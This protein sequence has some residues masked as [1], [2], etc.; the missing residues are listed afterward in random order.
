MFRSAV[1]INFNRTLTPVRHQ[2]RRTLI[3]VS[4]NTQCSTANVRSDHNLVG[5][6]CDAHWTYL[7][8]GHWTCLRNGHWTCHQ[9]NTYRVALAAYLMQTNKS[10]PVS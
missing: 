5:A 1:Q 4:V 8:N 10:S 7:R 3:L 9:L 6:R 2:I